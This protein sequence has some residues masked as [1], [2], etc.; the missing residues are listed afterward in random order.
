MLYSA[1]K[2]PAAFSSPF[3]VV[4]RS[5]NYFAWSIRFRERSGSSFVGKHSSASHFLSNPYQIASVF[6]LNAFPHNF[7]CCFYFSQG[8]SSMSSC[9]PA[10]CCSYA[11]T[12]ND[13]LQGTCSLTIS[14]R[15]AP[16]SVA[17]PALLFTRGVLHDLSLQF[18]PLI[19]TVIWQVLY[20]FRIKDLL[21]FAETCLFLTLK[22]HEPWGGIVRGIH[23]SFVF[24]SFHADFGTS[25]ASIPLFAQ[26]LTMPFPAAC[27]PFP[28]FMFTWIF[29]FQKVTH[30]LILHLEFPASSLNPLSIS[31]INLH[32]IAIL[33]M[34]WRSHWNKTTN[35][36]SCTCQEY[37]KIKL[38]WFIYISLNSLGVVLRMI[39]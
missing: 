10:A 28:L 37:L 9:R 26:F 5:E 8:F 39:M 31:D 34:Y 38:R 21:W 12:H 1:G 19:L 29:W 17:V 33:F 13:W 16:F 30:R 36:K 14:L 25:L 15:L 11:V 20:F 2:T 4:K 7:P 32:V 35:K 6:L 24:T 27:N 3:D 23:F 22:Q 18:S